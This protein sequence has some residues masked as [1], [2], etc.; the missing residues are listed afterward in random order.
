[1]KNTVSLKWSEWEKQYKPTYY[2]PID[3]IKE[4]TSPPSEEQL[5]FIK[6]QDPKYV[7]TW[8]VGDVCDTLVNGLVDE[9]VAHYYICENP[10]DESN[11]Y[12]IILSV[13]VECDCYDEDGYENGN[14]YENCEECEGT[15]YHRKWTDD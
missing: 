11:N 12:E 1:M 9:N 15:G 7:W 14:G 13:K 5:V 4:R 10:W 8:V 3:N 6:S 2:N